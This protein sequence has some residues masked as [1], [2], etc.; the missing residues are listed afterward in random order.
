VKPGSMTPARFDALLPFLGRLSL[1]TVAVARSV[2]VEGK[3]KA[4]VAKETGLSRQR[5]GQAVLR[6]QAADEKAPE[7]WQR[8]EI[9]LPPELVQQVEDMADAARRKLAAKEDDNKNLASSPSDEGRQ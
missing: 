1:D 4:E 7:G 5:V 6:V 2:L 9:W 8:I 3:G